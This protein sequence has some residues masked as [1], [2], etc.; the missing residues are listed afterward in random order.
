[1]AQS[2][3][4]EKVVASNFHTR[5]EDRRIT[6]CYL[7]R[8]LTPFCLSFLLTQNRKQCYSWLIQWFECPAAPFF[9][10]NRY[11]V[12]T[13]HS[14]LFVVLKSHLK[15]FKEIQK[16]LLSTEVPQSALVF[17]SNTPSG[18]WPYPKWPLL[19]TMW[20]KSVP[21]I[22]S[23]FPA[24]LCIPLL[25]WVKLDQGRPAASSYLGASKLS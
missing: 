11:C 19:L 16:P 4:Y 18:R 13:E 21:C 25:I 5:W 3:H 7:V 17:S 24:S 2:G 20:A 9:F 8:Y 10:L 12:L 15:C 14:S 23:F 1:M 22:L 6:S